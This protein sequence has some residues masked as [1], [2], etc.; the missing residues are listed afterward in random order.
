MWRLVLVL[1]GGSRGAGD[2][3]HGGRAR[4]HEVRHRS[5]AGSGYRVQLLSRGRRVLRTGVGVRGRGLPR[6]GGRLWLAPN[7]LNW[8]GGLRRHLIR[9]LL[10]RWPRI[11]N[12][13][14]SKMR[15]LQLLVD[16]I[17]LWQLLLMRM[18]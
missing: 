12:L 10:L 5:G 6:C 9:V 1:G 17:V 2:G 16:I 3:D 15:L 14:V 11:W 18:L 7:W 13:V 4:H 8:T